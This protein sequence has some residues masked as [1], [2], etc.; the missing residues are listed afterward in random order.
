M[1]TSELQVIIS[2]GESSRSIFADE[3]PVYGSN[4]SDIDMDKFKTFVKKR[5]DKNLSDLDVSMARILENLNLAKGE[6]LTLAGILL[7]G[8]N[9][10]VLRPMFSV[11]CI[12]VD[13]V[14]I[15]SDT[16][17]DTEPAIEGTLDVIFE[18]TMGFIDRN[19]RKIPEGEGFN[20]SCKWEIPKRVFEE[21][22]VNALIHRDYFIQST[23]KIFI[24]KDRVEILSPGKL[25]N[26]LTIDNVKNG[27]SI[28]RNPVLHS[29]ARDILPYMGLGTGISRAFSLYPEIVIEDRTDSE[30]FKII[31]KR[32]SL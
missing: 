9:R 15:T 5:F 25:P 19:M 27:I 17:S 6:M 29:T 11:H 20:S 14:V 28:V 21:F 32:K 13:D 8:E 2:K 31:I 12:S 18:K 22:I 1:E 3:L 4:I 16:Y 24:F 10:H 23:I 26:S 7:F 30:Q